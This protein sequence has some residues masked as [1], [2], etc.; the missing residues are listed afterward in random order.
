MQADGTILIDTSINED[1]FEAGTKDL[2]LAMRRMAKTVDGLGSKAKI[3]LQKQV[4]SFSKL[5]SQY[6][7]QAKKVE[8]LN[9]KVDEYKNQKIPTKEYADLTKEI[10]GL[11]RKLDAAIDREHKFLETGGN[12][13]SRTFK[14]IQYDINQLNAELKKAIA[15]KNELEKT[16]G[17]FMSAAD[18]EE[19]KKATDQLAAAEERLTQTER[20]L[21]T[22]YV[23][24]K[25]KIAEYGGD[26][27]AAKGIT[28]EYVGVLASMKNAALMALDGMKRLPSISLNGL[29][30]GLKKLSAAAKSAFLSLAKMAGNKLLSGLKKISSGIFGIHKAANKTTFGLKQMIKT[31]LLMGAMYKAISLIT[32]GFKEGMENL[33]QYSGE[34]NATLSGL[35]SSLTQL[36]NA[37]ATAFSPILTAIAPALNYLIGLLTSAATAVAQLASALTGKNTFVKAKKVQEDYAASLKD[38]GSAASK[39]GKDA[40][41]MLAPFDDLVQIQSPSATNSGG[42]GGASGETDPGDMFETVP[43][44][45]SLTDAIEHLKAL[46]QS[47]DWA[48][49]GAYM[50]SGINAGLQKI[51]DTINWENVGPKITYFV[52]AFTTTFNSLVDNINWEL[53]G[54]TLGAGINTLTNTLLLFIEGIDWI[55]LGN[56]FAEGANGLVDEIDWEN[57]GQLLISKLNI[58]METLYGFVQTFNWLQFGISIGQGI[59][60]AINSIDPAIW[61]GA[62]SGLVIGILNTINGILLETDWQAIG[63]KIAQFFAQIDYSGIAD[64]L[65]Y[66]LG[67]ALA[68]LAEFLWGVIKGGWDSVVGWWKEKAFED[69]KFTITGLLNGIVEALADIGTWIV[70][71]VFTPFIQGFKDAFG[72][73]SPSTVM[74]EMGGFLIDGLTLGI[75]NFIP[76]VISKF[77]EI[78]DK[79]GTKWDETKQK[80]SEKWNSIKSWLGT[81][82]GSIKNNANTKF[83]ELRQKVSGIWD[84]TKENAS[85]KWTE[86]QTSLETTWDS[87]KEKSGLTF[88]ELKNGVTTAWEKLKEN[89]SNLWEDEGISG[90]VKGAVNGIISAAEGMVNKVIDLINWLIRQINKISID[91]PD[92][93]FSDGFTIGFDIPELDRINLPRLASGTVIPP[94]AGEFAA[95]LGDNNR[96]TEVV[97]P[98]SAIKQALLE[99]MQESGGTG[100]QTITLR[101]E[102]SMSALAR[103]LKPELDRETVRKGTNLVIVGGR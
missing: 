47:E 6:S 90:I 15:S 31:S 62:L 76:N 74:S 9:Q 43:V 98:V 40:E 29:I 95:I 81:N 58:L 5:N 102:G 89:T 65:F 86:I 53:L 34:T 63:N 4:D 84:E 100:S 14:G 11:N 41:K 32:D 1:G 96:E 8:E 79:I 72:I 13:K 82:W 26:L 44:D 33:A 88:D 12:K 101:F 60:G 56:K 37:F 83:D 87:L 97:S 93:P 99:A 54:N 16:G 39:A 59:N 77:G 66:G 20:T 73:H 28:Q 49:L 17:A 3:A 50:A 19:G 85:L 23:A 25:Q 30:A 7:Q 71:H 78:K 52:N 103:V 24:L 21:G 36:K 38:T 45:N 57:L 92:T 10:D 46:I 68:S 48:G 55:N 70:D 75:S 27:N 67:A 2:E 69:G 64:S 94:R 22:A 42:G 91:V 18:T 51:Y 80:T 35:M 61:A